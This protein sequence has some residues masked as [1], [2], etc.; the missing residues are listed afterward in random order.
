MAVVVVQLVEGL[1]PTSE[2]LSLNLDISRFYFQSTVLHLGRKDSS[3]EKEAW[4]C[5]ICKNINQF[6]HY[7]DSKIIICHF[8]YLRKF[9]RSN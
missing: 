8:F 7:Y 2:I 9:V 6:I 5:H 3:T 4:N 1:L